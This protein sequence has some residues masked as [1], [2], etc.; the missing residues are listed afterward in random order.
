VYTCTP[1]KCIGFLNQ[2]NTS[3]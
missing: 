2:P 1:P 3:F